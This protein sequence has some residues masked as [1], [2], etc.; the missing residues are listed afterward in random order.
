MFATESDIPEVVFDDGKRIA[1]HMEDGMHKKMQP[2]ASPITAVRH[3][4]GLLLGRKK[5][6]VKLT[7]LRRLDTPDVTRHGY[8]AATRRECVLMP[9]EME[10][11]GS[12]CTQEMKNLLLHD[13]TNLFTDTKVRKIIHNSQFIIHNYEVS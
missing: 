7:V 12:G 11:T 4:A 5:K 3:Q 6:S 9:R 8:H 10:P 1:L 2:A 13:E